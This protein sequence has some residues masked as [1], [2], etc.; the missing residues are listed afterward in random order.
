MPSPN[1]VAAESGGAGGEG[2][3]AGEVFNKCGSQGERPKMAGI[4]EFMNR[5]FFRWGCMY[6]CVYI[7]FL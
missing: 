7:T 6:V 3:A 2:W 4:A 5:F 1:A